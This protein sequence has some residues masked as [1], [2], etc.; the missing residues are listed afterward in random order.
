LQFTGWEDM[1]VARCLCASML[2]LPALRAFSMADWLQPT[3]KRLVFAP[4]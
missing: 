4:K 2:L 3:K 1:A